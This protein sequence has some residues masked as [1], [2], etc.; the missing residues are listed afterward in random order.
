MHKK[1]ILFF[2]TAGGLGYIKKGSGT[3]GTLVGILLYWAV[4]A[5]PLTSYSLFLFTFIVF[6]IWVSSLA[7]TYFNEKDS[8]KIVIDEV[9]GFLVTML[10]IPFHWLWIALGFGLFRLFD[11]WKP[12]PICWIEKNTKG[13]FGVVIDDVLAGVVANLLLRVI[14]HL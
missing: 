10:A 5:L 4:Y 9:A 3:F 12:F 14:I 2:A 7:E 1:I 13:G 11:I 8:S 6:S